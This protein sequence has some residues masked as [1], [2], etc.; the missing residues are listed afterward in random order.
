MEKY[1]KKLLSE[2]NLISKFA[3]RYSNTTLTNYTR[4][5]YMHQA[6]ENR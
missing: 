6:L 1:L 3:P 5:V 4:G 2:L